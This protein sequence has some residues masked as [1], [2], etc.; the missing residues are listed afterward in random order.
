MVNAMSDFRE[1]E[2]L[3]R[4]IAALRVQHEN[5]HASWLL[6]SKDPVA[7]LLDKQSEAT[8][9]ALKRKIGELEAERERL[10]A[11]TFKATVGE[12]SRLEKELKAARQKAL[13]LEWFQRFS[14]E[15]K[16]ARLGVMQKDVAALKRELET[17]MG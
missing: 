4:E 6:K 13:E 8:L 5:L 7:K 10:F 15:D 12:K 2:L 11:E 1:I 3:N 16:L 9:A 17:I 14:P